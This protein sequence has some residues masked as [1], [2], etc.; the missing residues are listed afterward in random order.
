MKETSIE[1]LQQI[2][3]YTTTTL[4]F[5]VMEQSPR[6]EASPLL[7]LLECALI[8]S[9]LPRLLWLG[10]YLYLC[11]LKSLSWLLTPNVQAQAQPP[12]TELGCNDDVQIS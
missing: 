4:L 1:V 12:E 10:E 8:A 6:K 7:Q 3:L 11:L 9:L 2:R 5:V